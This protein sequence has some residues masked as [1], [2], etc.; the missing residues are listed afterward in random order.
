MN[1]NQC[2][3]IHVYHAISGISTVILCILMKWCNFPCVLNNKQNN[4]LRLFP[5][6]NY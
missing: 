6:F 2:M 5:F 3:K 1:E 4:A